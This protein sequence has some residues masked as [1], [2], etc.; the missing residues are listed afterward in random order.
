MTKPLGIKWRN[1]SFRGQLLLSIAIGV[2]LLA[3]ISTVINVRFSTQD[4]RN[5]LIDEGYQATET[6]A[7]QSPLALIFQSSENIEFF[8][9]ALMAYPDILGLGVYDINNKSLLTM[10]E[11]SSRLQAP[12]AWPE[13]TRLIR[14]DEHAWYFASTVYSDTSNGDAVDSPFSSYINNKEAIGYVQVTMGKQALAVLSRNILKNNLIVSTIIAVL[15]F[16]ILNYITLRMTAPI[17]ALATKMRRAELG[18]E[19]LRA[20]IGGPK[21]I[22]NMQTAFNTMMEVLELRAEEL[23]AARDVALESARIKG[24]FTAHITHEL[25]TPLN[26]IIGMLEILQQSE[27]HEKYHG[28]LSIAQDS[29][30][31]LLLLIN[32]ILDFSRN[33]SGKLRLNPADFFLQEMLDDIISLFSSTAKNKDLTLA[34]LLDPAIPQVFYGDS[35]RI[36]QILINLVGNAIKFTTHGEVIIS[37]KAV[38]NVGGF[39]LTFE[40]K[41]TGVGISEDALQDIFSPF[42]QEDKTTTREFGGTGL[43]LT[44]CRQLV[45]IMGGEIGVRSGKGEGSTFSFSIPLLSARN[46]NT[47]LGDRFTDLQGTRAL[48]ADSS[49][50]NLSM[51]DQMAVIWGMEVRR[52]TRAKDVIHTLALAS[53]QSRSFDF[54]I[55]S[56]DFA[57]DPDLDLFRS[58]AEYPAIAPMSVVIMGGDVED[59][60]GKKGSSTVVHVDMPLRSNQLYSCLS[61]CITDKATMTGDEG[62]QSPAFDR[63]GWPGSNILV[64][65]DN[66]TNQE[67]AKGMLEKLYCSIYAVSNGREA[68]SAFMSME[69]DLIFMDCNMPE[70]DGYEATRRIRA[71]ETGNKHLPIIAMTANTEQSDADKCLAAG[72]DDLIPKPIKLDGIR[73]VL[74]QWLGHGHLVSGTADG[75]QSGNRGKFVSSVQSLDMNVINELRDSI[76]DAFDRMVGIFLEDISDYKRAIGDAVNSGNMQALV[77]AAHNIKGNALTFGAERL[78]EACRN[79]ESLPHSATSEEVSM[80]TSLMLSEVDTVKDALRLEIL[81]TDEIDLTGNG[82][83]SYILIVDDDRTMRFGIHNAIEY[84]GYQIAEADNGLEAVRVCRERMP[85]LILMDAIMPVVDGF[86]ACA[87]IRNMPGGDKVPILIITGLE[88]E[89]SIDSAYTAGATDYIP[90]PVNHAVLRKR[91]ERL[92]YVSRAEKYVRHLAYNDSLT[93]LPNRVQFVEHL[94]AT[95]ERARLSGSIF[96]LLFLDLDRFKM[97]NDTMG[98]D[99]GDFLLKVVSERIKECIRSTDMVARLGGDEFTVILDDLRSI[100]MVSNTA[101]KI[102]AS[103]SRPVN[104]MDQDIFITTSIGISLYP[105]DG[106]DISAMM[107]HADTAMYCAKDG[108]AQFRFYEDEMEMEI[109][110]RLAMEG[111]LRRALENDEFVVYYQPQVYLGS[112]EI[113]GAEALVRWQHPEKGLVSPNDFI[114]I[115][116]ETGFIEEIGE[117]VLRT[118]CSQ[119]MTWQMQG[120]RP[121][122]VSVNLSGRQLENESIIEKVA[123]ILNETGLPAS[124]LELEITESMLMEP[125]KG[126]LPILEHLSKL[127]VLLAIDDFGT[128]YSSLG[129]LKHFPIDIL[130]IDRSFV[131]DIATN[132]EDLAIITGIIALAKSLNLKV[133][134]EGVEDAEQEAIL[135]ELNC[136]IMQG[137]YYCRPI[138]ASI[139]EQ[140]FLRQKSRNI[141]QSSKVLPLQRPMGPRDINNK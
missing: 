81:H 106:T 83:S 25:R 49:L 86:S 102:Y 39:I 7:A 100:D 61:Q 29:A 44:I 107:K 95:I 45:E 122:R 8:A 19:E 11:S 93:G 135:R 79:I 4:I 82:D 59:V 48:M 76:G 37:I 78:V 98:H 64:V 65:D 104:C 67:V 116:E 77:D 9:K 60:T 74:S 35:D 50:V 34:Y 118:S 14:E 38:E 31:S 126:V 134:A 40:V 80:L 139:F 2:L 136:D 56:R 63:L 130:K 28:Y 16:L 111:D 1:I 97:I 26:G 22:I 6:L 51:V 119:L 15:L 70:M 129:K 121:L 115:A 24:E 120:F 92:L 112:G 62:D 58:L 99:V 68:L 128:G 96:A 103:L 71:I 124:A 84:E 91:M 137:F 54:L 42:T 105:K 27:L 88:D 131:S 132:P 72:M 10:G 53:E 17:K 110:R 33:E 113:I 43:G 55:I 85:D 101:R 32:D 23:K 52:I 46:A 12:K 57:H 117:W 87:Q 133:V 69:F 5:R 109:S 18:E 20:D 94:K 73:K 108:G 3:I 66:H 127:G 75:A 36:R 138:P 21:D 41:D 123:V 89:G 114:H 13:E 140:Q 125:D 47:L 90:K 141:S 30:E